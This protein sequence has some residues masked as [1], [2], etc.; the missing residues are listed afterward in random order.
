[1]KIGIRIIDDATPTP[2]MVEF[3]EE[4]TKKHIDRMKKNKVRLTGLSPRIPRLWSWECQE[5]GFGN[6]YCS[7]GDSK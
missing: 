6:S 2:E 4:R 1:M 5:T 7:C 3:F